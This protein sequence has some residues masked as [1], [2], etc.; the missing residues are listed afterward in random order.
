MPFDNFVWACIATASFL[1]SFSIFIVYWTSEKNNFRKVIWKKFGKT[2]C[3]YCIHKKHIKSKIQTNWCFDN[4]LKE[5]NYV[6]PSTRAIDFILF[7]I[8]MLVTQSEP[9]W[10]RKHAKSYGANIIITFWWLNLPKRLL[11]LTARSSVL[12]FEQAKPIFQMVLKI[13]IEL[14]T[15]LLLAQ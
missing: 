10:L 3:W 15:G 13:S 4:I 7:P 8:V 9:Q 2:I 11:T 5:K 12:P 6:H 1:M 14:F